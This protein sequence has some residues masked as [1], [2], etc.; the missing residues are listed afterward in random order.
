MAEIPEE[1]KS[2]KDYSKLRE[3][4]KR[5]MTLFFK[6]TLSFHKE[7]ASILHFHFPR[8]SNVTHAI[9][10]HRITLNSVNT[11]NIVI[12]TYTSMLIQYRSAIKHSKSS[13][14]RLLQLCFVQCRLTLKFR[15]FLLVQ[16]VLATGCCPK[17]YLHHMYL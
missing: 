4:K 13:V 14:D 12:Y 9:C 1:Y 6:I 15:A 5:N 16:H 7:I 2:E 11:L 3:Y 17:Q 8:E 10:K